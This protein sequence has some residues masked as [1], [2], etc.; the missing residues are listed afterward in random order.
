M[1]QLILSIFL[2]LGIFSCI[3]QR[4]PNLQIK[5]PG[6]TLSIYEENIEGLGITEKEYTLYSTGL[7]TVVL[8]KDTIKTYLQYKQTIFIYKSDSLWVIDT[9]KY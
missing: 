1:K 4:H 5:A 6:S 9:I 8:D 2:A 7:K 3:D